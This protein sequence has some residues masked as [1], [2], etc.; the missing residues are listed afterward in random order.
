VPFTIL[1]HTADTG[2]EATA[3][4]LPALI[5]VLAAGMFS[6]VAAVDPCPEEPQLTVTAKGEDPEELVV[7]ALSGLVCLGEIEDLHLCHVEVEEI[8]NT[9]VRLS[10]RGVPSRSVEM[11]GPPIKAVT[12]HDL[13]VARTKDAWY[14]RVYLDV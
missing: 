13:A 7:A 12:L 9:A 1:D 14:G 6:T 5:E 3:E 10:A 2:I 11:L 8:S 4:S